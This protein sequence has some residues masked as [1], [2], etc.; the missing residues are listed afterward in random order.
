MNKKKEHLVVD[1][2]EARAGWLY[3]KIKVDGQEFDGRFS[4]VFDPLLKLKHWL[5]AIVVGVEQASFQYDSEGPITK[6]DFERMGWDKGVFSVSDTYE[7]EKNF[8]KA[9]VHKQ[10]LIEAFYLGLLTF[11]NSHKY[12][13][14]EW[15]VECIKDRLCSELNVDEETLVRQLLELNRTALGQLL[16]EFKMPYTEW[17]VPSDYDSWTKMEKAEFVLDCINAQTNEYEGTPIDDFCSLIIEEF[18]N[19]EIV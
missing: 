15:E 11:A 3:F 10:Q 2:H 16:A 14:K 17:C 12:R 6:F 9:N 7:N 13:P 4:V 19:G 1:F 18:L 5:E 8:I